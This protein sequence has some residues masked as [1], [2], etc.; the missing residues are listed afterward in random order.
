MTADEI[1]L[2]RLA[3]AVFGVVGGV[4]AFVCALIF[5]HSASRAWRGPHV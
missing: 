3:F 5:A 1:E 4:A 2:F